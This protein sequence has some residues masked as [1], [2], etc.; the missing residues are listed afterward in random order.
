MNTNTDRKA[1]RFLSPGDTFTYKGEVA[2][3]VGYTGRSKNN[4]M[5]LY[6]A[7]RVINAD[8]HTVVWYLNQAGSVELV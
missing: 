3:F 6:F 8:G 5:G 1:T 7:A 2:T 4:A